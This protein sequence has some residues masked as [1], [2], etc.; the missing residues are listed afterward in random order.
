MWLIPALIS[1]A[2]VVWCSTQN[3]AGDYNFNAVLTVPT[4]GFIIC[5]AWMIYFAVT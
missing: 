5:F 4:T 2:A 1:I 3:Y